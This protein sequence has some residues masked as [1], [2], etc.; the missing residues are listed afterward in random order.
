MQAGI[1][2]QPFG[3]TADGTQVDIYTLTNANGLKAKVMTYGRHPDRAG[4]A[5][6]ARKTR[7]C[8]FGLRQFR[9]LLTWASFLS[10]TVGR[11]ANRIAGGKFTLD[12]KEY[13]LA[14]NNGPNSLHGGIK[15]FDKAVWKASVL[16]SSE[17][18]AVKFSYTSADG[19]EGYPGEVPRHGDLYAH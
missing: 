15:G 9:Q 7:R 10:A 4:C 8:G 3:K 17:N 6:S 1:M 11:Y 2:K 19:E 16:G 18:P 13:K 5:R 12:G 14:V